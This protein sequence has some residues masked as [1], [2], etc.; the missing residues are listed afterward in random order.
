[1]GPRNI[2][3]F[4]IICY[5]IDA[6]DNGINLRYR[7]HIFNI[8]YNRRRSIVYFERDN[9][10]SSS[11]SRTWSAI[12]ETIQRNFGDI[13]DMTNFYKPEQNVPIFDGDTIVLYGDVILTKEDVRQRWLKLPEFLRRLIEENWPEFIGYRPR[14]KRKV[15][16]PNAMTKLWPDQTVVYDFNPL[17]ISMSW[18]DEVRQA[19]DYWEEKTCIDFVPYNKNTHDRKFRT[20]TRFV[21]LPY[22]A[23]PIG[24][25]SYSQNQPSSVKVGSCTF[26]Q[27][28]HEIGH[29]VGFFHE[30]MRPD[31]DDHVII[32]RDHILRNFYYNFE[33]VDADKIDTSVPYDLSSVMHYHKFAFS[34]NGKP[35]I[36]AKLTEY[37][38]L[39][40]NRQGMSFYD[41]KHANLAYNCSN[42]CPIQLKCQNEGYM[43]KNCKCECPFGLKGRLCDEIE[44]R[45]SSAFKPWSNSEMSKLNCDFSNE[46][47]CGWSNEIYR[48]DDDFLHAN[49]QTIGAVKGPYNTGPFSPSIGTHYIY[50]NSFY[51]FD[52]GQTAELIT[53][54]YEINRPITLCFSFKYHMHS[55]SP[56][57]K[58]GNLV[59]S[60]QHGNS[61]N[62]E[63]IWQKSESQS[64]R[65]TWQSASVTI[66]L[67]PPSFLIMISASK[68]RSVSRA[69]IGL[70]EFR[71][72][73]G[74]CDGSPTP[75]CPQPTILK[76]SS[77]NECKNG[78]Q[79]RTRFCEVQ[80]DCAWRCN[81]IK[82]TDTRSCTV[83]SCTGWGNFGSC[84]QTDGKCRRARYRTCSPNKCQNT[85]DYQYCDSNQCGAFSL[86]YTAWGICQP[87]CG[88]FRQRSRKQICVDKNKSNVA[89]SNCGIFGNTETVEYCK[90]V[91]CDN[92]A[93]WS[94]WSTWSSCSVTCGKGEKKRSRY[95]ISNAVTKS[96]EQVM[97]CEMVVCSCAYS[98]WSDWSHCFCPNGQKYRMRSLLSFDIS[99]C[100]QESTV[101][102]EQCECPINGEWSIWSEWDKCSGEQCGGRGSQSRRRSC[103]NPTPK[104]RGQPCFGVSLEQ[105]NCLVPE[106][107]TEWSEWSSWSLC[108]D[109]CKPEISIRKRICKSLSC[110]GNSLD[111]KE[112]PTRT[113]AGAWS[114]W[115]AWFGCQCYNIRNGRYKKFRTRICDGYSCSG[116]NYEEKECSNKEINDC[117]NSNE[118]YQWSSWSSWSVCNCRESAPKK[119]RNRQCKDTQTN[120]I[121]YDR[122]KCGSSQN[123]YE[124][125]ICHCEKPII[126]EWSEWSPCINNKQ[127]RIRTCSGG[128][129]YTAQL[130][131]EQ[132]CSENIQKFNCTFEDTNTKG[133]CP[134]IIHDEGVSWQ[135]LKSSTPSRN[136]GPQTDYTTKTKSG[137]YLYLEAT[138]NI[139]KSGTITTPILFV[140]EEGS[141]LKIAYHMF[142]M[143][144]GS[145]KIL[146]QNLSSAEKKEL[147]SINGDLGNE[148][149]QAFIPIRGPRT[150]IM[151]IIGTIGTT[152]TSDIAIDDVSL[153]DM[154][155]CLVLECS[156]HESSLCNEDIFKILRNS[157]WQFAKDANNVEYYT[158]KPGIQ[159]SKLIFPVMKPKQLNHMCI[160][161]TYLITGDSS[162]IVNILKKDKVSVFSLAST[163]GKWAENFIET[164]KYKIQFNFTINARRGKVALDNFKI[165]RGKCAGLLRPIIPSFPLMDITNNF[166]NIRRKRAIPSNFQDCGRIIN[167]SR[168]QP[169]AII[170]SPVGNDRLYPENILCSYLIKGEVGRKI[171]VNII[172]LDIE[173]SPFRQCSDYVELRLNLLGQDGIQ[174]CGKMNSFTQDK[175]RSVYNKALIIFA[176]NFAINRSGF[177]LEV[178]QI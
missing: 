61:A 83:C 171:G 146:M 143:S 139:K 99:N 149:H 36:E 26:G 134:L 24:Y 167:L 161:F 107:A 43:N 74:S 118:Q 28:V 41:I 165:Y 19:I 17:N 102:V 122:K 75:I 131:E 21:Q 63:A 85:V 31:R 22:C 71:L 126:S 49:G 66:S 140:P 106:C 172:S 109:S 160:Y 144:M 169:S 3:I 30:A 42:K 82:T 69:D 104:N 119:F 100:K 138:N 79:E 64:N 125:E 29:I 164:E 121:V 1:M 15:L 153:S 142:G 84:T 87:E 132:S 44:S 56:E 127:K 128:P 25:N 23:S 112:C 67:K 154:D 141:C 34:S 40:G 73:E 101:D 150:I 105:R 86:E 130:Q 62:L 96:N 16:I 77:W 116:N 158:L 37:E 14:K 178:I 55:H 70:D 59:L 4:S 72:R 137:K 68:Y 45:S 65:F 7:Q 152:F 53:T 148:W 147:F 103:N 33:K 114:Q 133:N 145:L 90:P 8:N 46:D 175:Y 129:C 108:T 113:C 117:S 60:I 39:M 173:E 80:S 177:Q 162:I 78:V 12:N 47:F 38:F 97:E 123:S 156:G 92:C 95:C 13:G 163:D 98:R 81:D 176:S 124:Y 151:E 166:A 52:N 115:S 2:L 135:K 10:R 91:V 155:D 54:Q 51:Y 93:V 58:M 170:K 5:I 111:Y 32:N 11:L 157:D 6:N 9:G 89:L 88:N 18:R 35:T 57:Y 168:N 136:T 48:D 50:F 20:F 76:W 120:Q 110:K 94:Q 27:I 174:V 159:Y